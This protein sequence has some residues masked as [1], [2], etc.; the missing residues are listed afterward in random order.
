MFCGYCGKQ[1]P[2]GM[3]FCPNCGAAL[4]AQAPQQ[5]QKAQPSAQAPQ[6]AAKPTAA[7]TAGKKK[8]ANW[9]LILIVVAVVWL[10][11]KSIGSSMAE[12][13]YQDSNSSSNSSFDTSKSSSAA[14]DRIFSERY[15][16]KMEPLLIGEE[17]ASFAKVDGAND[18]LCYDFGYKG[19]VVCTYVEYAY[20]DITSLS[21]AQKD[22]LAETLKQF[23]DTYNGAKDFITVNYNLGA[24]FYSISIQIRN[25]D[26]SSTLSYVVSEGLIT[27]EE[28]ADL[29]SMSATQ[30][31]LLAQGFTQK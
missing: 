26:D 30:E 17:T 25:L 22:A 2:D 10:I 4:S 23:H 12:D 7:A 19:D 29:I 11:G 16:V 9:L 1:A 31:S 3:K 20:Y 27:L 14:Y 21:D 6:Q 15:I 24:T 28:E 5:S 8:K 18:V 13:A